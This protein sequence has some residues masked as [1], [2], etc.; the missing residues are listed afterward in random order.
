M[1]KLRMYRWA[2]VVAVEAAGE[3]HSFSL[4]AL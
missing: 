4:F 2:V 3:L 1:K